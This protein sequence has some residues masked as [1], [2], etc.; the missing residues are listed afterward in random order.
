MATANPPT[1]GFATASNA[2]HPDDILPSL[3]ELFDPSSH[4][5]CE[6]GDIMLVI[7]DGYHPQLKIKVSSCV[8]ASTSKVFRTL[9][10]G[11]F[12]EG[13]AIRAGTRE[14]YMNDKPAPMLALCQLLHLKPV[15][16]AVRESEF[17]EF[18]LL[19]DKFD[20]VQALKPATD[21]ML[22]Q[23]TLSV[24]CSY[25]FIVSAFILDQPKHFRS[26]TKALV[27]YSQDL[28][29]VGEPDELV[30]EHL[31]ENFLGKLIFLNPRPMPITNCSSI[32]L[33]PA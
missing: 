1:A 29:P 25:D 26:S 7:E 2:Q 6:F 23:F 4:D 20:C 9:F 3:A 22:G 16:P 17:L 21:S 11:C 18:A 31:P 28:D 15:E 10:R 14:I 19:V 5:M 13:E 33:A 8:L 32:N 12:I 30:R 27:L 24:P